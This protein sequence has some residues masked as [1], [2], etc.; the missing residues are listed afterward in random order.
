MLRG[1]SHIFT[2]RQDIHHSCIVLAWQHCLCQV[3]CHAEKDHSR[4]S[5]LLFTLYVECSNKNGLF[6]GAHTNVHGFGR[7]DNRIRSPTS[8]SMGFGFKLIVYFAS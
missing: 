5:A 2:F 4:N 8:R 3:V 7:L 1:L 6:S